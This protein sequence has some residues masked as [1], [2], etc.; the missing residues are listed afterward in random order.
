MNETRNII[1]GFELGEKESQVCYYDRLEKEAIT[2]S[3]KV[4]SNE[5]HFPTKL[6]KKTGADVWHMGLEAEYFSEQEGEE[7]ITTFYEA[8]QKEE[9]IWVDGS[10]MEPSELLYHFMKEVLKMLGTADPVRQ[11]SAVMTVTQELS[12]P[13][14]R[15]LQKAYE[16]LG[17]DKNRCFMQDLEESFYYYILNQKPEYWTRKV[18]WITFQFDEVTFASLSVDNSTKPAIVSIKKGRHVKLP[19][20]AQERD[21][22]FYQ[23]IAESFGSDNYSCVYIVGPGFDKSWAGRSIPLLCKNQRH[24]FYGNNLFV[25]GA[26]YAAKEKV[27]DKKLKNYLY[28]GGALVKVNIGM[29][30][31]I[32]G[33]VSY[34]TII[35]AGNNWYE[36]VK[37][38]EI[39]LDETE[40]LIFLVNHM[41]G[42]VK[43]RYTMRLPNLPK[44][45]NKTTRLRVHVEYESAAVCTIQV[46]D[47]GFG[48]MY[49]SSGQVWTE[50]VSW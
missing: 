5:Y 7:A 1:I 11:I 47:M 39:I 37:D 20:E 3:P 33:T 27:E 6:S 26:C 10:L 22:A 40:E 50:R 32:Q 28:T 8:C 42:Q 25:K 30:M 35:E 2:I 45:P 41:D 38:F 36:S 24:V 44:R 14:V 34:Y 31:L 43:N 29:E 19:K 49:P 17:F 21:V 46:E 13:M 4:G 12:G 9:P 18:A 48:E 15:N 23:L 16:M